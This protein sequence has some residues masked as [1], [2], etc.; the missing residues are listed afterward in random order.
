M[1]IHQSRPIRSARCD[2][3]IVDD[4]LLMIPIYIKLAN[5]VWHCFAYGHAEGTRCVMYR[6]KLGNKAVDV[7]RIGFV[8]QARVRAFSAARRI[9]ACS[10]ATIHSLRSPGA[11]FS[12]G[13]NCCE[14][15]DF[16]RTVHREVKCS[17]IRVRLIRIVRI[18]RE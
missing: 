5:A 15:P 17:S 3:A 11:C 12:L 16:E 2:S 7:D 4:D 13:R 10:Y 6:Y 9:R 1:L 18:V 14:V 8:A